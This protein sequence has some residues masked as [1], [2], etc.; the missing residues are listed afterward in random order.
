ME[1]DAFVHG[2]RSIK[3]QTAWTGRTLIDEEHRGSVC[4]NPW[5]D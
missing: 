4:V 1:S 5:D 2:R 3:T